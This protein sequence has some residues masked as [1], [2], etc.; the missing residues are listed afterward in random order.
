M[1]A[2]HGLDIMR[3]LGVCLVIIA[4]LILA[5]APAIV[6]GQEWVRLFADD[7]ESGN[8]Q[9][10][11]GIKLGKEGGEWSI[12]EE[13]GNH[14]LTLKGNASFGTGSNSWT[15]Y[16]L[17]VRV[18]LVAGEAGITF[19]DSPWQADP[20]K[21][22][23]SY[24]M[25]LTPYDCRLEKM[26]GTEGSLLGSAPVKI[27]PNTWHTVSI[28]A[29]KNGL[30]VGIDGV[31]K[32]NLA[33][34]QGPLLSGGIGLECVPMS[35]VSFDDVEVKGPG[36][37]GAPSSIYPTPL[38][39]PVPD[40]FATP[41]PTPM[42]TQPPASQ[43]SANAPGAFPIPF[44]QLAAIISIVAAMGSV[45]GW[46]V[47]KRRKSAQQ[48]QLQK[49]IDDIDAVYTRFKMNARRCE[50]ELYRLK[51]VILDQLKR[52]KLA[53][54]SYE[55]LDKR[56]ESYMKEV[57]ERLIDERFGGFPTKLKNTLY[58]MVR[59]GEI[60]EQD[61][62]SMERLILGVSELPDADRAELKDLLR[63]WRDS[64]LKKDKAE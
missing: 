64:Y 16:G 36:G 53:K 49:T 62:D 15:D 39:T 29:Y 21:G 50:A 8:T 34:N 13:A 42:P 26:H 27:D 14:F 4:S 48:R 5:V 28:K 3:W 20:S 51:E 54:E 44:D 47:S 30:Y 22:S 58:R 45:G 2:W 37:A 52:G 24:R 10:W 46:V 23:D 57:E 40:K 12:K 63:R 35:I 6:Q 32:I 7:F 9:A 55:V 38:P 31:D 41:L 25:V 59:E 43:Q 17:Q 18:K 61:F 33:D 1:S 19:R 60:S 56:L 11:W